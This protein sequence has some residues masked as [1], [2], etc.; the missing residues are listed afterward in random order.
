MKNLKLF[1]IAVICVVIV[2][3]QNKSDWDEPDLS[4]P[5]YGNNNSTETNVITIKEL[6]EQYPN[7][8]ALCYICPFAISLSL[9]SFVESKE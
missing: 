3:C 2:G 8:F 7:V 9:I 4:T 5:Q 1:L 6:I